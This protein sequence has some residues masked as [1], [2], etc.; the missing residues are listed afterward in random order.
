MWCGWRR[1]KS[2]R[3]EL[4]NWLHET[5][6]VRQSK[7]RQR[8]MRELK[9]WNMT[10]RQHDESATWKGTLKKQT[11]NYKWRSQVTLSGTAIR[12]VKHWRSMVV[13]RKFSKQHETVKFKRQKVAKDE[14]AGDWLVKLHTDSESR[15]NLLEDI[16]SG[17]ALSHT[18]V[19]VTVCTYWSVSVSHITQ[20]N[21]KLW[22][23]RQTTPFPSQAT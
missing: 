21:I 19:I 20:D 15:E 23:W 6:G 11:H 17:P 3:W 12:I 8:K 10:G 1:N 13:Q 2:N 14:T 18:F 7:S 9:R 22:G 5:G 4:E 16:A